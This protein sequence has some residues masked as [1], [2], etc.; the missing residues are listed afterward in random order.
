MY[1]GDVSR[2]DVILN[3]ENDFERMLPVNVSFH[4]RHRPSHFEIVIDTKNLIRTVRTS[5]QVILHTKTGETKINGPKVK[6]NM[7]GYYGE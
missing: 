6:A 1:G 3:C 7:I 5:Y 2:Y 4:Y